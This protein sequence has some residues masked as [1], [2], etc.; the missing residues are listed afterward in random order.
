MIGVAIEVIPFNLI[1]G[2]YLDKLR[3][4]MFKMTLKSYKIKL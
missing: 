2:Y 3:L 1:F 4:F